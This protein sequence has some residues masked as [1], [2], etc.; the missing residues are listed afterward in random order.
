MQLVELVALMRDHKAAQPV[1]TAAV[2][3]L[4]LPITSCLH[5]AVRV[6]DV[7]VENRSSTSEIELITWVVKADHGETAKLR[8][9]MAATLFEQLQSEL[10]TP[11]RTRK[12]C[13]K[14]IE[15]YF[16]HRS[17]K[18]DVPLLELHKW[19]LSPDEIKSLERDGIAAFE[20]QYLLQA[21]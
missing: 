5:V 4:P 1:V 18:L 16:E 7:L 6:A 11:G 13:E 9:L 8:L 2:K 15:H 21:A 19:V 14:V 20:Q 12:F 17:E 3:T 10:L